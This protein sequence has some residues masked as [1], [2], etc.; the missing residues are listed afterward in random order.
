MAR[1][2]VDDP[3]STLR[4]SDAEAAVR[5]RL[6]RSRGLLL[7]LDFDGTLTPIAASP[8]DPQITRANAKELRTLSAHPATRIA[9]ISGR[10]LADLPSRVGIPNLAYAGNHGLELFDGAGVTVHPEAARQVPAIQWAASQLESTLANVP[11]AFVENKRLS[12]TVHY[13]QVPPERVPDVIAAVDA[14]EGVAADRFG[15]GTATPFRIAPGKQSV[16]IRPAVEWDKGDAVNLLQGRVPDDWVTVYVGDDTT[17]EDAF[18]VLGPTDVDVFV[19]T[20]ETT[21]TYRLPD[22]DAVAPFLTRLAHHVRSLFT[23]PMGC[24]GR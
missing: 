16:E 5:S 11:G 22:Q 19:G 21:A 4:V 20:G 8:M 6:E 14:T 12:V 17:D 18:A 10:A 7:C 13:R 15:N 2:S 9:I 1:T 23:E 3:D 24:T